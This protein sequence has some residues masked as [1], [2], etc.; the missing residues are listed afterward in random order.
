MRAEEEKEIRHNIEA[1]GLMSYNERLLDEYK[2]SSNEVH[3]VSNAIVR[4]SHFQFSGNTQPPG[5]SK[6]LPKG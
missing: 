6:D 2:N 4:L 1:Q 5:H 3:I